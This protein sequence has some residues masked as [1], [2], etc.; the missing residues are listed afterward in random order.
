MHKTTAYN[1]ENINELADGD[2]KFIKILIKTFIEE[3][4]IDLEGL[5][6]AVSEDTPPI[7]YQYAHKMKPNF[8]LFDIKVLNEIKIIE[9]WNIGKSNKDEVQSALN[10]IKKM[11]LVALDALKQNFNDC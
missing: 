3:I 10:S 7:A 9:C 1:L 6:K 2:E 11:T 8:E 5:C 4:P